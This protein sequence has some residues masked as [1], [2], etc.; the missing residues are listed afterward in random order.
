V[1]KSSVTQPIDFLLLDIVGEAEVLQQT[2]R[3]VIVA[4]PSSV[5]FP[6]I[7]TLVYSIAFAADVTTVGSFGV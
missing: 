3:S 7:V 6:P 2:P 5:I 1:L 4:P